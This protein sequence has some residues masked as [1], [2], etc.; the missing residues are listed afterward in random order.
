MVEH[1]LS[2]TQRRV[3]YGLMAAILGG[4]AWAACPGLPPSWG[5][6]VRVEAPGPGSEGSEG[7]RDQRDSIA[8]GGAHV[9]IFTAQTCAACHFQGGLGG[10]G[11]NRRGVVSAIPPAVAGR[12]DSRGRSIRLVAFA[13]RSPAPFGSIES[14]L[15][16]KRQL[17]EEPRRLVDEH[18]GGRAEL[19][20]PPAL[21]G[22]GLVDRLADR[23]IRRPD[24][25]EQPDRPGGG[26]AGAAPGRARILPDGRVGKFGRKAQ[27]ATLE[28]FLAAGCG[29]AAGPG[30]PARGSARPAARPR[31]APGPDHWRDPMAFVVDLP[32]P[33]A[34]TPASAG[35]AAAARRGEARFAAVGCVACH[36]PDPGG[37]RAV[38]GDFRLHRLDDRADT[39]TAA[40]PAANATPLAGEWRTAP[41]WG[42]A[43]SA[44]YLHDGSAATLEAAIAGHGGDASAVR[45]AY[46]G[47]DSGGR[48]DVVAFLR[49]LRAPAAEPAG[50]IMAAIPAEQADPKVIRPDVMRMSP[51]AAKV[52]HN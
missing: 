33:E 24:L 39:P 15:P 35:D 49:T 8:R 14:L 40:H 19:V 43:D 27:F 5:P 13:D 32:P 31:P 37:L 26:L 52:L 36:T 16:V 25:R 48:G 4:F 10:G 11:N 9:P 50:G 12:T 42:V 3:G 47:L 45:R 1:S 21:F 34:I 2:A 44:P 29:H 41:L 28:E 7:P 22:L 23:A 38:Y 6:R 30:H 20:N 51:A 18:G 46:E 17:L